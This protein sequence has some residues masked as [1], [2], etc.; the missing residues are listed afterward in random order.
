MT[1]PLPRSQPEID[2]LPIDTAPKDNAIM[3][4]VVGYQPC[5]GR[6]WPIDSCWASFDWEGHFESDQEMTDYVNGTSY[7]PTH[8][9]PLPKGP[10]VPLEDRK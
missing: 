3:L 5:V 7:E 1:A 10:V 4:C 2:W 6:W 9:S 8:W